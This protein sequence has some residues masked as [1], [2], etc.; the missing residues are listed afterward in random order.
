[1]AREFSRSQR[2]ADYLQR[3]L[4]LLIQQE[5]DDPRVGMVSLTGVDVSRDLAHAKVWFTRLGSDSA[6]E[7]RE[8]AV[9]L[10]GAAGYLRTLLSR[11]ASMRSVPRLRFVFD[12]SVGRGRHME[13]LIR[14]AGKRDR[15]LDAGREGADDPSD[16]E[17]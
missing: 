1:M 3:E 15:A 6:E 9:A 7:A 17:G 2:V 14:E 4:A 5:V 12:G 16:G 13:E 11:E 8:A 10:N